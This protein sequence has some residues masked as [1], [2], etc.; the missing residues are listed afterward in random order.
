MFNVKHP[1]K[2]QGLDNTILIGEI[3]KQV[4]CHKLSFYHHIVS[5]WMQ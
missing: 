4:F 1:D 2:W 5:D 3:A